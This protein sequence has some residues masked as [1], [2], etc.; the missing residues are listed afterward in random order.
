VGHR[1]PTSTGLASTTWSK[2]VP[3]SF[4][5]ET[6]DEVDGTTPVSCRPSSGSRFKVGRT[7]SLLGD[8][9]K[10]EYTDGG[11]RGNCQTSLSGRYGIRC[12]PGADSAIP[13]VFVSCTSPLP[14]ARAQ[15]S[16]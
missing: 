11:V 6:N 14:F 3:C 16:S 9:H 5:G 2:G 13:Y 4:V 8:R 1:S 7:W 10:R 12:Q 15:Y